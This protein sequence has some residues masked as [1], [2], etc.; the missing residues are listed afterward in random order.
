ME[1][2]NNSVIF[3]KN[4]S[5]IKLHVLIIDDSELTCDNIKDVIEGIGHTA[6]YETDPERALEI[7]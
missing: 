6:T 2:Y 7:F 1:L 3:P 4:E 5:K